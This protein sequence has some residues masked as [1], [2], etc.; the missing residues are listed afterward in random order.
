MNRVW[1]VG[2]CLLVLV[3]CAAPA[4]ESVRVAAVFHEDRSATPARAPSSVVVNEAR[5]GRSLQVQ[6]PARV[7]LT[8]LAPRPA[9]TAPPRPAVSAAPVADPAPTKPVDPVIALLEPARLVGLGRS[10]LADLMGTP[11]LLRTEPP[12]EVWLYKSDACVAHVYLYEEAGPEDYQVHYVETRS[13]AIP[14][15]SA[16]CLAHLAGG[17]ASTVSLNDSKN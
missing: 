12:G 14:V 1:I 3:A 4:D 15:S 6:R 8:P 17:S 16:Q 2:G 7:R 11:E 9:E 13:Q 10:A 5:A